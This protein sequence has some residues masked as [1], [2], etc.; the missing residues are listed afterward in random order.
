MIKR[1]YLGG[2]FRIVQNDAAR[3]AKPAFPKIKTEL[4]FYLIDTTKLL[5]KPQNFV[6]F[7]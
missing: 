5:L 1:L 3:L 6:I 7:G 4:R 2:S